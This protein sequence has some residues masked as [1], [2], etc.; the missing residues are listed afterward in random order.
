MP[1]RLA[2]VNRIGKHPDGSI[3]IDLANNAFETVEIT[4]TGW[5][6]S[7][8]NANLIFR[9]THGQLPLPHPQAAE[10]GNSRILE[11]LNSSPGVNEWL[12]SALEPTGPFPILILHGPPNSGKSTLAKMLR[13]LIDPVTTPLVPLPSRERAISNL[14][15]RHRVLAFD[16]VTRMS[17][18]ATDALCRISSGAGIRKQNLASLNSL[19]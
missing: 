13:S 5:Q 14:A 18:T 2:V 11:F 9:S 19:S 12:L 15:V 17:P 8:P 7:K 3:Q 16:H 1:T 10:S 6:V 4:P